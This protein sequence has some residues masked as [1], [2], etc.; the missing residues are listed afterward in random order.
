MGYLLADHE[1][2]A[3]LPGVMLGR[4]PNPVNCDPGRHRVACRLLD[5]MPG[6]FNSGRQAADRAIRAHRPFA[7]MLFVR[8]RFGWTTIEK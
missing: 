2:A 4:K 8:L 7:K 5:N 3:T 1:S 6:L